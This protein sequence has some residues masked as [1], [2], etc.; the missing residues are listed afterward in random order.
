MREIIK[1]Y[2]SVVII[3]TSLI[4]NLV[5]SLLVWHPDG[6]VLN[7]TP[8]TIT[9]AICDIIAIIWFFIGFAMLFFDSNKNEKES[10]K[11]A[12]LEVNEELKNDKNRSFEIKLDEVAGIKE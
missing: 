4:F 11:E 7:K 2:R 3:A 5:S 1:K 10:I 8:L 9:E 6:V 12:F